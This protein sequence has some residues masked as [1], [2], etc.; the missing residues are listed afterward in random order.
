MTKDVYV[1]IKGLQFAEDDSDSI[2][3]ITIGQLSEIN[4][5]I[6]IKYDD[7]IEGEST[8]SHN[9]I[10]ISD[11]GVEITKKGPVTAH[12]S[13]VPNQKTMTYYETPFGNLYLGIFARTVEVEK[14]DSKITI[15]IDYSLEL[16]YEHISE[17]NVSI[18]ITQQSE[19]VK[20]V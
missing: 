20:L 10:K 16:N 4:H 5:S 12:M 15:E 3:V 17:C 7:V 11:D 8:V 18:V 9:L 1:T 14:T 13:F 19:R 6:Y 2:E